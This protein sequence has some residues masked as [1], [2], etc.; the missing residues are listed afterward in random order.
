MTNEGYCLF[1]STKNVRHNGFLFDDLSF[2]SK[3]R[4]E[5]LRKWKL[6][7]DDVIMTTRW[8]IWNVAYF[9]SNIKHEHIRI[10]SWMVIFRTNKEK[11]LPT[12]LYYII[13]SGMFQEKITGVVSWSAQPQLPIWTIRNITIPLPNIEKQKELTTT[14]ENNHEIIKLLSKTKQKKEK[15]IKL[16]LDKVF[17]SHK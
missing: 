12:Y 1:L 2:I 13:Q 5:K 3:A 8:T 7:H 17:I 16:I 6:S 15:S 14:M 10:N 4:D 11:L 9:D